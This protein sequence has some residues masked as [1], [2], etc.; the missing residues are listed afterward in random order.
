M[1]SFTLSAHRSVYSISVL[2][3]AIA[4]ALNAKVYFADSYASWQ[5]GAI[6]NAMLHLLFD[7]TL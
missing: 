3:P 4:D 6:K 7:S 1:A 2:F 5:K